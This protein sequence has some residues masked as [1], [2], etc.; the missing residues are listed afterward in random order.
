MPQHPHRRLDHHGHQGGQLFDAVGAFLGLP[1]TCMESFGLINCLL[2]SN[3]G[4]KR[5]KFRM[6]L[7]VQA[8]GAN[9]WPAVQTAVNPQNPRSK[10]PKCKAPVTASTLFFSPLP[11]LLASG[12]MGIEMAIAP[13]WVKGKR[14]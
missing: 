9:N 11:L 6:R 12:T 7:A 14:E 1:P 3:V 4:E 2:S 5:C 10:G 13:L 8:S